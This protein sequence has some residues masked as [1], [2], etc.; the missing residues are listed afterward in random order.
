M[1]TLAPRFPKRGHEVHDVKMHMGIVGIV[2]CLVIDSKTKK[3]VRKYAP[4]K[5]LILNQGMDE[6]ATQNF[7]DLFL[8]SVVGTGTTPTQDDSGTTT[9]ARSGTTVTLSGGSFTF[10]NTATDAGKMIKWDTSEEARIV[11]VTD[12]TH[13]EVAT[14]GTIAAA[15]FTVFRTNQTGLA[16]ETKRTNNYLTGAGNTETT[17]N[18]G[19]G[20]ISHKRT[21]DH[22]AEVGAI[23]YNELGFSR[24]AGAG[25]NL[26]SRIL[27]GAGVSLVASQ[28]L[29][30]VYTLTITFSPATP[31]TISS[32]P[33]TGWASATGVQQC[34]YPNMTG[35]RSTTGATDLLPP[36]GV[37][38]SSPT[39]SGGFEPSRSGFSFVLT[40]SSTA[41]NTFGSQ[42]PSR[43]SG[44]FA[45]TNITLSTYTSLSFTRTKTG[46]W[47]TSQGNASTHRSIIMGGDQG[48]A[49]GSNQGFVYILDSAQTKDNT[50]T[51]T[52]NLILTWGRTLA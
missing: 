11:T 24:Q 32:T 43:S 15:Q 46:V 10:T 22:T 25:A 19:A 36:D 1:R 3:V 52:I 50:H 34:Q 39:N 35:I 16:T 20:T 5:N 23:T 18:G 42:G 48:S 26:F 45:G 14:S 17:I 44:V 6:W 4:Q 41:H 51:L 21:Y 38:G 7:C 40:S 29:R 28:Q 2:Q 8:Y 47:S 33:I 31:A 13:C 37:G 30:V 49:A 9:A 12:T 27:L